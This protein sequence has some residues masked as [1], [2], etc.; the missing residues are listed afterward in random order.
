MAATTFYSGVFGWTTN[1]VRQHGRHHTVLSNGSRP[2]VGLAP[3]PPSNSNRP[4]RWI[5]YISVPD[6]ASTVTLVTKGVGQV[7]AEARDFPQRGIQAIIADNEGATDSL[8]QSNSGDSPD[9]EPK[10]GD[11]SWFV[12]YACDPKAA[13][14]LRSK[15]AEHLAVAKRMLRCAVQFPAE[16]RRKAARPAS[17]ASRRRAELPAS[18]TPACGGVTTG[19]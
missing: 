10:T 18:D 3:R 6:I 14:G 7:R 1:K 2:V 4:S 17:P 19:L 11:W 13:C 12:L 8:I 16:R 15:G 9:T 5:A